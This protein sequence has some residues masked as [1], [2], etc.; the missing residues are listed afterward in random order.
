MTNDYRNRP[1]PGGE[2]VR[3]TDARTDYQQIVW[4]LRCECGRE[5]TSGSM[6][7]RK[8]YYCPPCAR[9][10]M[11]RKH[12]QSRDPMYGTWTNMKG[13]C[14]NNKVKS[15]VDYGARGIKVC[16]DW[17]YNYVAYRRYIDEVL[18]PRP[19]PSHTIDRIDNDGNYEPGNLRWASKS[20]QTNNR[21]V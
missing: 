11:E 14:Y 12:G 3:P 9:K 2:A 21:R 20:E 8:S 7:T 5:H 4:L 16:D 15:F 18:G 10:N 13:R 1:R 19:T 17:R 6:I